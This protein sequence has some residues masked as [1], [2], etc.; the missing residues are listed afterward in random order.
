[1]GNEQRKNP[2]RPA[3][4]RLPGIEIPVADQSPLVA[5]AAGGFIKTAAEPKNLRDEIQRASR[6]QPSDR[7]IKPESNAQRTPDDVLKEGQP[8]RKRPRLRE[9]KENQN[10]SVS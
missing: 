6:R 4:S 8:K 7:R 9:T 1:M 3:R 5:C 10:L 2:N